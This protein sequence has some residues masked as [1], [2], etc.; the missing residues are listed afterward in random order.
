MLPTTCGTG[1]DDPRVAATLKTLHTRTR[2]DG[3]VFLR[4]LPAILL[5][6]ATG[7]DISKIVEPYLKDAYISVDPSQG[8]LLYM[9][10]RA[11][12]ARLIVE[13]GTSFAIS[14]I[15]LGAAARA[16]NGR[17]IGTEM[18][19]AKVRAA[20]AN[21]AAAGLAPFVDIRE[22]DAMRTLATVEGPIDLLLLDGWK[23]VYLPMIKML[24]P[25]MHV[26]TVVLADNIF[27]Y[28][29]AL[30]PY[31]EYMQDRANGFDSVTLPIGF[32]HGM[33]YSVRR[34]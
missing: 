18:E 32:G 24:A 29:K 20:R 17:V 22:G 26:G 34:R 4:A 31:V 1:L 12:D 5:A 16:N 28:K 21:V 33:E 7:R 15:Y 9:T 8:K 6:K 10:A 23:D 11:I 19:P 3:W 25:R 2:R 30:R 27:T 14:T 13:F